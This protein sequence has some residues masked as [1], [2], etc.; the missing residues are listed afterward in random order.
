VAESSWPDPANG[1]VVD[2]AGFE[3]LG[4]VL[5]PYGGVR[6]DFTSPAL[7]Y[8]DSSGRQVKVVAD[9]YA[10]VRGH[11]WYSG[12]T[13]VTVP[14]GANTSGSTRTDLVVLRYSRTTYN[15]TLQVVAGTPGSGAPSPTQNTGTTGVWELPLATV[16]V[17][18]NASTIS[19]ANVTYVAPHIGSGGMMRSPSSAALSYI[20]SSHP[21]QLVALDTGE[22]WAKNTGGVWNTMGMVGTQL[23]TAT[24]TA[25][26]T[27]PTLG[28]GGLAEGRYTIFNG[29]WCAIRG[30]IKFGT[31][32]VSAG[33]GQ[34]LVNLPFPASSQIANGNSTVGSII[35]RDTAPSLVIGFG[36]CYIA[37]GSSQMGLYGYTSSSSGT[38]RD[39]APF[40][41]AA[42]DDISF[43]MVYEMA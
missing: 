27:N 32:G 28:S 23:Y 14:I 40:T 26:T 41:W 34:Y 5:G 25:T 33:S 16:S 29:K 37:A 20:P 17:A 24:L 35:F 13:I 7:V 19:A 39:N 31:S 10:L 21:A 1:R 18:N 42:N 22:L 3:A 38:I 11:V 15:V 2:D 43:S 12:P 30:T 6:G 9:R 8:G 36:V 4:V